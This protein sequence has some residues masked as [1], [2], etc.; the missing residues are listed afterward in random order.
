MEGKEMIACGEVAAL[1][2][3]DMCKSADRAMT[4]EDLALWEKTGGRSGHYRRQVG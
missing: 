4:I 2:I 3:Y 1:T